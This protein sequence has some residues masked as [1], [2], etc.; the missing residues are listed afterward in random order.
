MGESRVTI[1]HIANEAGVSISTVSK[2][3]SGTG[4]MRGETRDRVEEV[5]RRLGTT[6]APSAEKR[7]PRVHTR[8]AF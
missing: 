7:E 8:S 1:S 2:A 4:R 5:A 3:L 6:T